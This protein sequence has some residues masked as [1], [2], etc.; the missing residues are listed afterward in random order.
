MSQYV[1]IVSVPNWVPNVYGPFDTKKD[2][3]IR[4]QKLINDEFK[5]EFKLYKNEVRLRKA[6]RDTFY[7]TRKEK[8][9]TRFYLCELNHPEE[10]DT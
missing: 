4:L 7:I 1:I 2:A 6:G 3:S 5:Q 10:L 8:V 9:L